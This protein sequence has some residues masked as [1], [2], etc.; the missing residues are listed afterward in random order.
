MKIYNLANRF[1]NAELTSL[2]RIIN[3]AHEGKTSGE[4]LPAEDYLIVNLLME[5]E[6]LYKTGLKET[7]VK[8]NYLTITNPGENHNFTLTPDYKQCTLIYTPKYV[9][10][11]IMGLTKSHTY[12][13]D[14]FVNPANQTINFSHVL[15]TEKWDTVALVQKIVDIANRSEQDGPLTLLGDLYFQEILITLVRNEYLH[16]YEK[17]QAEKLSPTVKMELKT[18]IQKAVEYISENYAENISLDTLASITG[19]SKYHFA[20]IFKQVVGMNPY[21]FLG[22]KRIESAKMYLKNTHLSPSEIAYEVGFTNP[23]SF[24]RFFKKTVKITPVQFRKN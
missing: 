3:K 8:P 13:L 10:D 12:L 23:N 15:L 24:Y 5:G 22:Q 20:R 19:M 14:N 7:L 6:A 18:R 9:S 2:H 4:I 11:F 1:K 21:E 16:F 17:Q